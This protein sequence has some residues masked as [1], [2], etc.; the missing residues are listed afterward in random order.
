MMN[1]RFRLR[2]TTA[3]VVISLLL[4]TVPMLFDAPSLDYETFSINGSAPLRE[5]RVEEMRRQSTR[6][7][8]KPPVPRYADVVPAS[9]VMDRVRRLNAEVDADGFNTEDG[10]R[11]GE[12]ILRPSNEA[13]RVLAV[14]VSESNDSDRAL[15]LRD[16][17]REDG[18]EA[19]TSVCETPRW[20]AKIVR[21][22]S[23]IVSRLAR[24]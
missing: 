1:E 22:I 7:C 5:E 13:S 9:D 8:K 15:V 4:I 17:L 3:L 24:C 14:L 12:P 21:K 6:R 20:V 2:F 23:F 18:Y 11:F 10:T 16:R 19:F